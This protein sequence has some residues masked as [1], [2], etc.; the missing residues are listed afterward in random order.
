LKTT[1]PEANMQVNTHDI[2]KHSHQPTASRLTWED[3]RMSVKDIERESKM[4]MRYGL[5]A[6][7][8]H[9]TEH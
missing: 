8:R 6:K 3:E 2:N 7:T 1:T 5:S 4:M 9:K